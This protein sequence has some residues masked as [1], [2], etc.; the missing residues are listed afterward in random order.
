MPAKNMLTPTEY[1]QFCCQPSASV[2]M[3]TTEAATYVA[4]ERQ[5][6]FL[7]APKAFIVLQFDVSALVTLNASYVTDRQW[8]ELETQPY[9]AYAYKAGAY[10]G[11][12]FYGEEQVIDIQAEA[13]EAH[14]EQYHCLTATDAIL[15]VINAD[16]V[17]AAESSPSQEAEPEVATAACDATETVSTDHAVNSDGTESC[18]ATKMADA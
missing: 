18:S 1:P 7:S 12:V 4:Y 8:K 11:F 5:R 2:H 14:S 15:K 16:D 6:D 13:V 9:G 3:L 10:E 17:E